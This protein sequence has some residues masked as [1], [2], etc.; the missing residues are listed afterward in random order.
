MVIKF[1]TD[2]VLQLWIRGSPQINSDGFF[3][4][5]KNPTARHGNEEGNWLP[6]QLMADMAFVHLMVIL[7]NDIRKVSAD[8]NPTKASVVQTTIKHGRGISSTRMTYTVEVS[9]WAFRVRISQMTAWRHLHKSCNTF[10][11]KLT[12]YVQIVFSLCVLPVCFLCQCTQR[13][14]IS[15]PFSRTQLIR[16]NRLLSSPKLAKHDITWKTGT[17]LAAVGE[18]STN[19]ATV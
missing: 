9:M 1:W 5:W 8:Q 15:T 3:S 17:L 11:V 18:S 13:Y 4:V 7:P 10:F 16:Q 14:L 2:I 12:R 6:V 19:I